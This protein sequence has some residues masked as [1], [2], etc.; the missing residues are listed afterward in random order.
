MRFLGYSSGLAVISQ[1]GYF[2]FSEGSTEYVLELIQ[3]VDTSAE[4]G[5]REVNILLP[6]FL[7]MY[8]SSGLSSMQ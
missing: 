7:S 3:A 5:H 8:F 6:D 1:K 4:D 2:F